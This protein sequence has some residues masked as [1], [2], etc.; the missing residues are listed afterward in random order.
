MQFHAVHGES[1]L[2]DQLVE[3]AGV[4]EPIAAAKAR[5][6]LE[7]V[8]YLRSRGP[9]SVVGALLFNNALTIVFSHPTRNVEIWVDWQDHGQVRNGVPEMHYRL[10]IRN[11]DT[12]LSK[13]E[14]AA[15]Y[16]EAAILILTA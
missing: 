7:L 4:A 2:I 14:R 6:L 12:T 8:E 9:T 1:D 15:T 16:L 10:Q 5:M 13:D 3:L 11:P